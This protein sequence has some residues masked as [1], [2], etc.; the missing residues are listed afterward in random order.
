MWQDEASHLTL[1]QTNSM[2]RRIRNGGKNKEKREKRER[3]KRSSNFS[4]QSTEIGGSVFVGLRTIDHLIDKGYAW[5]LKTRYFVEDSS[6]EFGK[7]RVSS[8]GSVHGTS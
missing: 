2:G 7:S 3:G 4:L 1:D 5:V 6:E 8:L